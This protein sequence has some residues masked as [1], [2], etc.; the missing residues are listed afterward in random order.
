M[1]IGWR[2]GL[3]VLSG[4]IEV[5]GFIGFECFPLTWIAK[6]P[7]LL[8][9]RE[10]SVKQSFWLGLLYGAVTHLGFYYWLAETLADFG[11]LSLV[12]SMALL[13]LIAASFALLFA[14][15]LG[16]VQRARRTLGLAPVWTLMVAYPALE[17]IFPNALPYNIGASQYRFTAITQI[18]EVTGL[19]GLTAL[20][21]MVNGAFYELVEARWERRRPVLLRW[22]VPVVG[23]LLVLGYGMI[24]IGQV[25]A[26][27]KSARTLKVGL[28]Q[29]NHSASD[30]SV[31]RKEVVERHR[32]MTRQ[33]IKANQDLDLVVWPET[34]L[35]TSTGELGSLG[36]RLGI[37][38]PLVTGAFVRGDGGHYFN[39]MLGISAEG[40]LVGRFDK[41]RL[42]PFSETIPLVGTFP[43]L[44]RYHPRGKVIQRGTDYL[45]LRVAGVSALPMICYEDIMPAFVREMWHRAGPGEI[46]I[47]V[48]NDSWFGDS[49]EPIMHLALASFRSIETRRSLIRAAS[50]GISAFVDP[51]GRIVSRTGQWQAETLV[52]ETVIVD[53]GPITPYLRYGDMLGW[54]CLALTGAWLAATMGPSHR[55]FAA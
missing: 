30:Q 16:L 55:R 41:R 6:V 44:E 2:C 53:N 26:T 18:V 23:F 27:I 13:L 21:G 37:G 22:F 10:S 1:S 40:N 7:V 8:A 33:L 50:T 19:L 34:V 39:S 54:I 20:I 4:I 14:L 25:D 24:R 48:S 43:E 5:L 31:S 17:F 32:E 52:D 12:V 47:N 49:H 42:I 15:L 28:I 29:T 38:R 36:R 46:L 9:M 45:N 3:A 11:G 35:I 51:V